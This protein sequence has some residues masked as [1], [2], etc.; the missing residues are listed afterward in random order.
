MSSRGDLSWLADSGMYLFVPLVLF[1][2]VISGNLQNYEPFTVI[3]YEMIIFFL[4]LTTFV[5]VSVLRKQK[6]TSKKTL[7][8]K[9]NAFAVMGLSWVSGGYMFLQFVLYEQMS[10]AAADALCLGTVLAIYTRVLVYQASTV[11]PE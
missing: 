3:D 11:D 6:F 2:L 10:H 9:A 8:A 1:V 7:E 4:V 5:V